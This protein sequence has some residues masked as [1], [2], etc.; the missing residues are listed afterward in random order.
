M[1]TVNPSAPPPAVVKGDVNGDGVFSV[2]DVSLA[3]RL[4]VKLDAPNA[5]N[6]SAADLNGDGTISIAEVT[7]LLRAA[8]GLGTLS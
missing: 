1:S 8:V 7:Q 3:L 2:A 4:A 5:K 6:P